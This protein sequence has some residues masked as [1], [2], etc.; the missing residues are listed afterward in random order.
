MIKSQTCWN[1][2]KETKEFF[3]LQL[4]KIT[5]TYLQIYLENPD[6]LSLYLVPGGIGHYNT[7]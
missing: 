4:K 6:V 7:T 3:L 2:N 1:L 5:S